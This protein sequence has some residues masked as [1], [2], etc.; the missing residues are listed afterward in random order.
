M[1]SWKNLTFILF[2]L[3]VGCNGENPPG[4][5]GLSQISYEPRAYPL[6]VPRNL[7]P[8]PDVPDNPMTYD[9]VQLGRHLFYDPI[10]SSD[11]SQSC[12]SCHKPEF[13]FTD[14]LAF[15]RGVT[16]QFGNRSSMS[17]LNIAYL[18]KGYFWDGRS[19]TLETQALEPVENPIEL[20]EMW[21][22]VVE[23]FKKHPSYPTMFRKAFGI[24][25]K[26]EITK[27]L[28]AK[29]IAQFERI[30]LTGGNSLYVRQLNKEIFFDGD[31]QEGMDMYFNTDLSLPDAQCGHCHAAPTFASSDYF[32]NGLDK[33]VTLDDFKDKGRGAVTGIPLDMGR[34]KAPGLFNWHLTA[35]YMHD[36]R[37]KTIEEV[38]DHYVNHVQS[39]P[40]LDPNVAKLVLT[41]RQKNKVIAFLKT[42]IDTSYLKNPDI[43]SPF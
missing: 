34:F 43:F 25:S 40:N 13:A 10:L 36:G 41:T 11:S 9:G 27:E 7:P 8:L 23:K 35:P 14:G 19:P 18:T 32:N 33:A 4:G 31:Q 16:G 22:N 3:I 5:D 1:W 15:S 39:A 20:H 24:S 42:L 17:L 12:A 2:W 37:F 6:V 29:A 21:P 38:M 30:L 26:S 28:A